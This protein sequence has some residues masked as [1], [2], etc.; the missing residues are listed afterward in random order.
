VASALD[1]VVA[2]RLARQLC[3]RC[4]Q[5]Y[6][7]SEAEL[8]NA[9]FSDEEVVSIEELYRPE[10]CPHCGKTGYRGRMGLYEVMPVSEEIERLAAERRSS[11]DIRRLAIEQGMVPLRDDGLTKVRMG[12]TSLDEI[13][14]VVV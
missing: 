9:G 4:R 5:A 13:F 3:D 6:R 7:P 11:D 10:G 8:Q 12:M 14:R 2:Q 1:C